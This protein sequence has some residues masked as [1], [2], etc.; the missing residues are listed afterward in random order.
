M[1]ILAAMGAQV[2]DAIHSLLPFYEFFNKV[3][4]PPP[5][6]IRRLLGVGPPCARVLP[7]LTPQK[8]LEKK[9]LTNY[10]VNLTGSGGRII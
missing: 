8:W 6:G 9:E 5:R 4:I 3:E 10:L 7:I 1:S 2:S